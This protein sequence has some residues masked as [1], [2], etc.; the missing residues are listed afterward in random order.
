MKGHPVFIAQHAT[1]TCCRKC[2]QKWHG[3]P[4]GRILSEPEINRVVAVIMAWIENQM[5]GRWNTHPESRIGGSEQLSLF[6][7][8]NAD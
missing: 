6:E 1:A 7:R 2:L 5:A 4:R 8:Q 3:L